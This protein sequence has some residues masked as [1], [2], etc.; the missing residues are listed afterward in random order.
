VSVEKGMMA[1][2]RFISFTFLWYC[3][4]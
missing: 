4:L 2:K 1:G 3:E